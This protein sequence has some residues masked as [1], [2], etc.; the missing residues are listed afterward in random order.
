M[1]DI[2]PYGPGKFNTILDSYVYAVGN[3]DRRSR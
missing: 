1:G 3:C 2:R